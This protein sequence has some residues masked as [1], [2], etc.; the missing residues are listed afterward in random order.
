MQYNQLGN[1]GLKVSRLGFG[2]MRLPSD[3][4]RVDMEKAAEVMRR[5]FDQGVNFVDSQY[6]YCGDQSEPAVG[7]AVAGRRDQ[8]V[9]QTK[10]A[11]YN[12][13]DYAPG[14]TH[15]T[16]LEETLRRI[17]SD[18]LDI[19]LMHGLSMARWD[20]FGEEWMEM[21]L[22]AKEEGLV[23]HIGLS[24]HDTPE[25][26][27]ALLEKGRFEVILMQYNMLDQRYSGVFQYARERGIGTMAMGPVGGGR[28]AGP[29]VEWAAASE[30]SFKTNAE[31]ALRFVLSNP[32]INC[33]FSGMRNIQEVDENCATATR[34]EP[35][36]EAE[37]EK[38]L[39]VLA[40]KQKLSEL[41]CSGCEYC[42]PCPNNV[43]ISHIFGAMALWKIWGLTDAAK[44]RY[45]RLLNTPKLGAPASVCV[46]CGQCAPKCPQQ[47]DIPKQLK[48]AAE[49]FEAS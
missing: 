14:E 43:A 47:I 3:E 21:A 42:M 40:E 10:A 12:K 26:V 2:A 44:S 28:L 4:G 1:T 48:E 46:A 32:A 34:E 25:R 5:A 11:Y 19:Y 30:L 29:P 49:L 18:Y 9:V 31:L 17:Q 33:A 22:K 16:R 7:K 20:E 24:T 6:H 8:I 23:R 38:V 41:Y 27:I 35:L 36:T 13:P 39:T 15:R 37:R 45:E